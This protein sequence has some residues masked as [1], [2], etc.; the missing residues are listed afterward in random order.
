MPKSKPQ[1]QI[2]WPCNL[3]IV[4][5]NAN[6][7]GNGTRSKSIGTSTEIIGMRGRESFSPVI[8]HSKWWLRY[9]VHQFLMTNRVPLHSR[10][11]FK[12]RTK[13]KMQ[14]SVVE[15]VVACLANSVSSK[16]ASINYRTR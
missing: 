7:V 3:L 1:T 5:A 10:G 6:V 11:G 12:S 9:V 16:T 14:L 15:G 4:I 2:V 13:I 8:F